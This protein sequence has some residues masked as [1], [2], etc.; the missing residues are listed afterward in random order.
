MEMVVEDDC[1]LKQTDSQPKSR[2]LVWGS[3]AAWRSST[4]TRWTE[5]TLAMTSIMT[6][7]L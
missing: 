7:V 5:W 3:V 6:T 1:C 4:F 2:G